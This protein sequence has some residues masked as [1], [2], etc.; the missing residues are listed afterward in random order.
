MRILI[1]HE[2]AAGGGGVE[3]Y[4]ASLMPALI[5]RGH[6]LAFL[7]HNPRSEAGP[8]RLD[9]LGVPSVS[10]ADEGLQAAAEWTRA[11]G[12]DVCFSHNMRPLD[13]DVRL[14]AEWPTVKMMH[15]YFGTCVS[16]QKAH[17]FPS[18]QPCTRT[19]GPA[20]LGLYLPRH[21][22]QLRPALM[23]T[24][25]S[26]ASQQQALFPQYA[27]IVVASDYM[28][29]EYRRHGIPGER[30]TAAPLFPTIAA[31]EEP[32]PLPAEPTVLFAGRMTGLKGGDVLVRAV[33]A[34]G[35]A[36]KQRVRLVLAGDGPEQSRWRALA[37]RL[38]VAAEFTGWVTGAQRVAQFRRA[39][40]VAVPSLW[41]EPFGL[42]GLEAAVHGVPAVA[43]DAGG[44]SQWLRDEENGRL[45]REVGNADALGEAIASLMA[46]PSDLRRL[47]QGAVRVAR[48][49]G[50]DPHLDVLER[51]FARAVRRGRA[52]A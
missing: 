1:A 14:A 20:C 19:F 24:Q 49:L 6:Q 22:G 43:F 28:A 41:P 23:L 44:I 40:I 13:V 37:G 48:E 31:S 8:T 21:C 4:L 26:W 52:V 27:H 34:A 7:H 3:S 17:A 5:A 35:R 36:M 18:V 10:V 25:Y 2:A 39:T 42:V 16:G 29:D 50:I 33:A 46:S 9:G 11:W 51:V 38:D 47:G 45:V 12:P 32:R 15:G 30:V